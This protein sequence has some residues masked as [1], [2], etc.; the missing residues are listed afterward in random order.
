MSNK[1]NA[2]INSYIGGLLRVAR[3]RS[4]LKQADMTEATGLTRN[5]ISAVERGVSKASIEMLLGYCKAL[6]TT[7][8][9]ILGFHEEMIPELK[10]ALRGSPPEEQ[11]KISQM[12]TLMKK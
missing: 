4:G 5:H 12:I 2:E 8:D 6:H 1:S 10:T 11:L 3:E 9:E 7:P